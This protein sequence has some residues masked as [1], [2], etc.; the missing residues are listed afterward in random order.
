MKVTVCGREVEAN[1]FGYLRLG[2]LAWIAEKAGYDHSLK[3]I[4]KRYNYH[5]HNIHKDILNYLKVN[6]LSPCHRGSNRGRNSSPYVHPLVW[7]Y[8]ADKLGMA[9][10]ELVSAR[11]VI[12][13]YMVHFV[14]EEQEAPGT[15]M[16]I[17]TQKP[18]NR[19]KAPKPKADIPL[20]DEA[21]EDLK[22]AIQ[23]QMEQVVSPTSIMQNILHDS[24]HLVL[25][26]YIG[27]RLPFE[28]TAI[29]DLV[30]VAVKGFAGGLTSKKV[31]DAM[32]EYF[33]TNIHPLLDA[34]REIADVKR[35]TGP[36]I[37][38]LAKG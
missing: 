8:V 17:P 2:D 23:L 37:L 24:E 31:S 26:G 4:N 36:A 1:K 3:S 13:K 34:H 7:M 22:L 6:Q 18:R 15:P 25:R 11:S 16:N 20:V 30:Q 19:N 9:V 28:R 27:A 32:V 33:H 5:F 35:P 21:M 14:F 38:N 10:S 12:S 29:T